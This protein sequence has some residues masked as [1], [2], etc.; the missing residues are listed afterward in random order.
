MPAFATNLGNQAHTFRF[1]QKIKAKEF[2][3]LLRNGI[4]A[5]VYSGFSL[6]PIGGTTPF[7]VAVGQGSLYI[8][9]TDLSNN[10]LTR[11]QTQTV[12]D[13]G[14]TAP[15]ADLEYYVYAQFG[16]FDLVL[17]FCEFNISTTPP[18]GDQISL[19]VVSFATGGL[20]F[21]TGYPRYDH[22]AKTIGINKLDYIGDA[23]DLI[24]TDNSTLVSAINNVADGGYY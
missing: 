6:A 21:N 15:S 13:L 12:I 22:H 1:K 5:G 23:R 24:T 3:T 2:N 7:H 16:W 9:A 4:E 10:K 19:G 11:I 8:K 14:I 18:T 20:T 17:N